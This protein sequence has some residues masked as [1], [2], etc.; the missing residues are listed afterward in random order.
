MT[1]RSYQSSGGINGVETAWWIFISN[2]TS[3][4]TVD[5]CHLCRRAET[6]KPK[7]LPSYSKTPRLQTK[8]ST[9]GYLLG[10]LSLMSRT[11]ILFP[12]F[13]TKQTN[14]CS[15]LCSPA[16]L[17]T[18]YFTSVLRQKPWRPPLPFFLSHFT[19]DP[20]VSLSALSSECVYVASSHVSPCPLQPERITILSPRECG[21][22]LLVFIIP[23]LLFRAGHHL[24]ASDL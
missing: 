24:A 7:H 2:I 22:W 11:K 23:F 19:S 21:Y 4:L 13:P 16:Q 5:I 9:A 10:I 18:Q 14:I 1:T 8:W 17:M 12:I 20:S 3:T 6:P 15:C